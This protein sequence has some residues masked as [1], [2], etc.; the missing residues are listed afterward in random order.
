MEQVSVLEVPPPEVPRRAAS[1]I[2]PSDTSAVQATFPGSSESDQFRD[3]KLLGWMGT[4]MVYPFREDIF[5][6]LRNLNRES[7]IDGA[8]M[9]LG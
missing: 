1:S 8:K 6:C 5:R 4:D 2:V 3:S 7:L 9:G